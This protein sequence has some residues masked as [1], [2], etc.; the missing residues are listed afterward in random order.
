[1][2]SY[3]QAIRQVI[4]QG[5]Y[6][7]LFK[8]APYIFAS[9]AIFNFFLIFADNYT[10]K[11][12]LLPFRIFVIVISAA[13]IPYFIQNK[14]VQLK[15]IIIYETFIAFCIPVCQFIT[16]F[17]NVSLW[18]L[19]S[20]VIIGGLFYGFLS[21]LFYM[22]VAVSPVLYY[23]SFQIFRFFAPESISDTINFNL[24]IFIVIW[25][26]SIASTAARIGFDV[27]Y[28]LRVALHEQ[29]IQ[30]ENVKKLKSSAEQKLLL[31]KELDKLKSVETL[32][33]YAGGI[34]H[35]FNNMLTI[36][37]GQMISLRRTSTDDLEKKS[38]ETIMQAIKKTSNLIKKML[39]FTGQYDNNRK[40]FALNE[41]IESTIDLLRHGTDKKIN[42]VNIITDDTAW[43]HGEPDLFQ[44]SLL[45][46]LFNQ[47]KNTKGNVLSI[48]LSIADE[49]RNSSAGNFKSDN[50]IIKRSVILTIDTELENIVDWKNS[51]T[52]FELL[53]VI[54]T[55]NGKLITISRSG[56]EIIQINF[57]LSKKPPQPEHNKTGSPISKSILVIDD[58][59]MVSKSTEE[60]LLSEGYS[61]I[62][63]NNANDA[64]RVFRHKHQEIG[65]VLL[66]MRMP[67][68]SGKDMYY[69]LKKIDTFVRVI[70]VS[71]YCSDIDVQ[72]MLNDGVL[73][74][75]EKPYSEDELCTKVALFL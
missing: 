37:A 35:D 67:E 65:L 51:D 18:Y 62:A 59:K 42:L 27:Y 46:F 8:A 10:A 61:V 15:N 1:M 17:D 74:Y 66:D 54:N 26:S 11:G 50:I 25:F 24:G 14:K 33:L 2:L 12:E 39:L 31:E 69:E 55:M 48:V 16:L 53:S 13:G 6:T 19:Y 20:G 21:G 9:M 43:I 5:N 68:I 73:E 64:I 44:T 38:I 4:K 63:C 49:F 23:L 58:D 60:L 45:N 34:A 57:P 22:P 30:V 70:I 3:S 52:F 7:L 71:G 28:Y 47:L 75:I 72:E 41:I 40:V 36:I 32:G 29:A 56:N